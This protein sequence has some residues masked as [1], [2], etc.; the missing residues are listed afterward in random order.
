M[1]WRHILVA[2]LCLVTITQTVQAQSSGDEEAR[3]QLA[4]SPSLRQELSK[5]PDGRDQVDCLVGVTT[6]DAEVTRQVLLYLLDRKVGGAKDDGISKEELVSILREYLQDPDNRKALLQDLAGEI[7]A[8]EKNIRETFRDHEDRITKLEQSM[9]RVPK[10]YFGAD[11]VVFV[12]AHGSTGLVRAALDMSLFDEGLLI[13]VYGG[14][15]S[16]FKDLVLTSIFGAE[17]GI[18]VPTTP[19]YVVLG[20]QQVA[21]QGGQ[22]EL[23]KDADWTASQGLLGGRVRW[24]WIN[25]EATALFGLCSERN[26]PG[27]IPCFGFQGAI[28]G[29]F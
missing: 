4:S 27:R 6:A 28:G 14:A 29:R 10:L 5:C 18:R 8:L 24:R 21:S 23:L 25:V 2:M 16:E 1:R 26:L 13:S 7:V 17:V 11:A 19:V 22:I 20:G 9:L 15:G 12:G 3:R